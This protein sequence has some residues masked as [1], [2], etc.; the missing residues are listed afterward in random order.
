MVLRLWQ[1]PNLTTDY[2]KQAIS[3]PDEKLKVNIIIQPQQ[4][5]KIIK[6]V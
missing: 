4:K 6:V 5:L 3:L 1:A 2:R